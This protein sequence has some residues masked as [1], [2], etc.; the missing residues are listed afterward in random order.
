MS[1]FPATVVGPLLSVLRTLP[2]WVLAG[3]ALAG[4]AVLFAPA[5]GGVDPTD[6]R[7]QWGVWVWIEA[8]TFSILTIA[9][10]MD[11]GV[12][13]YRAHRQAADSSRALRLVPRQLQ[14]WWHLAKQQ[15]DS[16]VSQISLK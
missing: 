8:L 10:G 7:T 16:F 14:S 6:F 2:V 12:N 11:A 13:A 9:R 3:F 5:F 4:Y 1:D 15:D